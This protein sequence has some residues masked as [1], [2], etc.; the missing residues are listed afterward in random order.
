VPVPKVK[1]AARKDL[2]LDEILT[3]ACELIE[4]DGVD[5]FTMRRL[6][7]E[8]GRSTMATYRHVGN[9]DELILAAAD[10]VLAR[11]KLP[12]N[13][14]ASWSERYHE[15][16]QATWAAIEHARWIPTYL[17][18]RQVTTPNLQRI[19]GAIE[20]IVVD[21]GLPKAQAE[22]V[23]V[24][25]WTFTIGLLSTVPNPEPYLKFGIDVIAAGVEEQ[26]R[27]SRAKVP[28]VNS[29]RK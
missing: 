15:V 25:S 18:S 11:V 9:K 7:E 10:S 17:V 14:D 4:R 3:V 26:A 29:K 22:K 28:A 24:M 12:D 1:E 21:S 19:M 16:A 5:A 27:A 6:A 8:L 20:E 23:V 13:P 2:S